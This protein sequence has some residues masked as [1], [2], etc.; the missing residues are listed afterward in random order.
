[1]YA[2]KKGTWVDIGSGCV[3]DMREVRRKEGQTWVEAFKEAGLEGWMVNEWSFHS[4]FSW[5]SGEETT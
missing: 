4:R 1:M 2:R 3:V 5:E